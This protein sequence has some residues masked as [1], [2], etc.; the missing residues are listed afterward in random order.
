M[1]IS[2]AGSDA[3]LSQVFSVPTYVFARYQVTQVLPW[4]FKRY[5][6]MNK[7]VVCPALYHTEEE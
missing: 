2:G 1:L 4:W 5:V 7:S 6:T 3:D